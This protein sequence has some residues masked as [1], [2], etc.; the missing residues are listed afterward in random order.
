MY[1]TLPRGVLRRQLDVGD[2]RVA[3]IV[4]IELAERA[5]GKRL[6]L[7]GWT[8]GRAVEGRRH[9]LLDDD[10]LDARIRRGRQREERDDQ[11]KTYV[12]HRNLLSEKVT[13]F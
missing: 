4:G 1:S 12:A 11:A 10:L 13:R 9:L 5:A 8:E 2:D 7:A 6:V 3:R